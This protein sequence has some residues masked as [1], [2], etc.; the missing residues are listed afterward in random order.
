[1]PR[2]SH[3]EIYRDY[4]KSFMWSAPIY[5]TERGLAFLQNIASVDLGHLSSAT[6]RYPAYNPVDSKISN[7]VAWAGLLIENRSMT[8]GDCVHQ[9]NEMY[10]NGETTSDHHAAEMFLASL[11]SEG[12]VDKHDR[13]NS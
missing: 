3:A 7:R 12:Y 1:M 9:T 2:Q 10:N 6:G 8:R 5:V 11:Y 13:F 4:H